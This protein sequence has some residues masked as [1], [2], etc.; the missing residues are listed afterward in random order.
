MP[1]DIRDILLS[2]AQC[3]LQ[4]EYYAVFWY[5]TPIVLTVSTATNNRKRSPIKLG[6]PQL[7]ILLEF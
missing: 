7:A 5:D 3:H 1:S 6:F 2:I 4:V